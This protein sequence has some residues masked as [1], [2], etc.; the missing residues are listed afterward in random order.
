MPLIFPALVPLPLKTWLELSALFLM[1]FF[2]LSIWIWDRR[3]SLVCILITFYEVWYIVVLLPFWFLF[4]FFFKMIVPNFSKLPFTHIFFPFKMKS[5]LYFSLTLGLLIQSTFKKNH[6]SLKTS[7]L[8]YLTVK[9]QCSKNSPT[10]YHKLFWGIVEKDL[11][12]DVNI[13][14]S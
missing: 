12:Q 1:P 11:D 9:V 4:F 3:D 10:W 13:L 7:L 2:P 6:I 14:P 5:G 8:K